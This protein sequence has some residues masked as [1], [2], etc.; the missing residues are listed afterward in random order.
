[1]ESFTT[2]HRNGVVNECVP[3]VEKY[4]LIST[5][6]PHTGFN[7]FGV[8]NSKLSYHMVLTLWLHPIYGVNDT[9]SEAYYEKWI[10]RILRKKGWKQQ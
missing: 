3:V 8:L 7:P 1:M 6:G 9:T 2:K 10:S 4:A 5:I